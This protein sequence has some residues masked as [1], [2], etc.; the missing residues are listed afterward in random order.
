MYFQ[1]CG[2]P[3]GKTGFDEQSE[4]RPLFQ[5]NWLKFISFHITVTKHLNQ[6]LQGR[7]LYLN[8]SQALV[9]S[10]LLFASESICSET[11]AAES[12]WWSKVAEAH[13]PTS[14]KQALRQ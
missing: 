2:L 11:T 6:Q 3:S 12:M 9:H 14:P 8:Q 7:G 13:W 4:T 10:H 1:S 5:E